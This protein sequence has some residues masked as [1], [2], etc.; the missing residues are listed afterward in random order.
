[1]SKQGKVHSLFTKPASHVPM[2]TVETLVAVEGKGI[3]HDLAFGKRNRQ[4]LLIELETLRSFNL[5]PGVLRE[6]V[7]T[8]GISYAG[9]PS[10][11]RFMLG[12]AELEVT[13]DCAP[14]AFLET[15]RAGLCDALDGKR[16]TLCRVIQ[17]GNICLGDS[18]IFPNA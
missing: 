14:C 11:T 4:V 9:V 1:M 15:V 17:G 18:I 2:L 16:G 8:T 10:G 13:M 6:N 12:Q 3:L 7:V 5:A